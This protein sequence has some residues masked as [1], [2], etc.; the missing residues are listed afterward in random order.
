[1]GFLAEILWAAL[2]VGAPVAAF[3]LALVRWALQRGHLKESTD[4][5]ALRRELKAMSGSRKKK[6]QKS[7]TGPPEKLH[8][9]QK[10]WAKFGGGFYGVVAFFTYIVIEVREVIDTITHLGGFFDFIASL[11]LNLIIRMLV[12]AVL[13]FVSA[14]IWPVYW[15]QRIETHQVWVWFGMAYAGYWCGLKLAQVLVQRGAR[16]GE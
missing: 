12:Q 2:L 6:K 5:G 13:N 9:L 3:T 16:T 15:M 1:V 4:T 14:M 10:K 11:D 8:P 7:D